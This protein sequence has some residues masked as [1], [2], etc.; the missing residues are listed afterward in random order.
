MSLNFISNDF[1]LI[2]N[3]YMKIGKN[4][5]ES[6]LFRWT[7]TIKT[8]REIYGLTVINA[9][10]VYYIYYAGLTR[11]PLELLKIIHNNRLVL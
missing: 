5:T 6:F 9:F 3:R 7:G 2:T 1:R 4:E 11:I 8:F 10:S